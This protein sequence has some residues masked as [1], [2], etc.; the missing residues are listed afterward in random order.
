MLNC[1][2]RS[3]MTALRSTLQKRA[4]LSFSSDGIGML[5]P[6]D[7]EVRLDADLP[8]HSDRMLGRLGLELARGPQIR[9]QRE[10]NVEA[11][12]AADIERK[13]AD[14][15]QK[16]QALDIADRTADLG[17]H[18]VDVVAC[19]AMDGRFDLVGDVRNHLDGLS[20][21]ELARSLLLDD[22]EVDF[23]GRVVAV[24]RQ[25]ARG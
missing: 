13:L 21:V 18:D 8:E 2:S 19:Q 12:F 6:A 10:M 24:A 16:R 25:A 1:L 15:F 9:D 4:I 3:S 22:R 23:S 20:L 7:Q 14:R 5:G 17:D 11:V